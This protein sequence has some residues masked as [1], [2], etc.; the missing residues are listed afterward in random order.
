MMSI[1]FENIKQVYLIGIGG[2]GMSALA[3]YFSHQGLL[4]AGYDCTETPLTQQ[5]VKEGINIH[6]EDNVQLIP[7]EFVND[8]SKTL[9]I[10]TPAVPN[11]HTE[12]NYFISNKYEVV[13]RAKALGA[14]ASSY[15]TAAVAGTH[16]KTST[17]SLLAHLLSFTPQ[18]CNAFLGGISKNLNSNLLLKEGTTRL[19][20]E[21]DEFDRSFLNLNPNIAIVTSV[22]ADHLDIYKAHE[23]VVNAFVEF[24]S[25]IPSGGTLIVKKGIE[26][27]SKNRNDITVFTYSANEPA[28]FCIDNLTNSKGYFSFNLIT[29]NGIIKNLTLGVLGK[30]NVENAIAASAAALQWGIEHTDLAKGLESFKGISRRFDLQHLGNKYVYIDDYAHHPEEIK[31]AIGSVKEMFPSRKI[32]GIFQPHLYSRTKDFANEF[33]ES[34]SLLDSLV[35]LDIYP[36]REEPIEGVTSEIIL[37]K[38]T[39]EKKIL[40]SL[41]NAMEII[42]KQDIDVLL[43]M[44]AGNIDKLV[45]SI[46]AMLKHKEEK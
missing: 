15:S 21:A 5:L 14:I 31:A 9:I 18:G 24:V 39:C 19:V 11:H 40:C 16:G 27:I 2:I 17:S 38:V 4:V 12:L 23:D 41:K 20:V 3:R 28:D 34:L 46:T 30:Y 45:N 25:K 33:A 1:K 7:S 22:D 10:Y 43:T 37:N 6:F 35:L 13:K 42:D 32:T 8:P 44:G 26:F 29:P 36:A